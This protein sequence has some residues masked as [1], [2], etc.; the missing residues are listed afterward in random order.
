MERLRWIDERIDERM[1]AI[2]G[3][4]DRH[5]EE[6]GVL[7]EEMRAGFATLQ[8]EI[9]GVRAEIASVRSDLAAFQRQVTLIVAGFGVGLLGVLGAGQL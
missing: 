4:F 2:D 5:F 8:A 6:I 3:R 7:R 1:D 9:G